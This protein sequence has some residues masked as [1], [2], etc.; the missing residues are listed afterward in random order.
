MTVARRLGG[1]LW[2]LRRGL[3]CWLRGRLRGRL[4]TP[5]PSTL[6]TRRNLGGEVEID[7]SN[8]GRV[9]RNLGEPASNQLQVDEQPPSRTR[10]VLQPYVTE[11][12]AEL[13]GLADIPLEDDGL[14]LDQR[15]VGGGR[16]GPHPLDG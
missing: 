16:L 1:R 8:I 13:I 11:Q 5:Q 7:V 14:A 15:L 3:W 6:F 9:G 10:C 2:R 12:P 4:G